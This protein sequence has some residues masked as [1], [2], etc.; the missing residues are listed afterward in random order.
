MM[1][2]GVIAV[3]AVVARS[4]PGHEVVFARLDTTVLPS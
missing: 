1:I 3:L 2:S 4:E